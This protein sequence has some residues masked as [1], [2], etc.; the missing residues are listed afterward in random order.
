MIGVA[1]E[2]SGKEFPGPGLLAQAEPG[3]GL[4]KE[5]GRFLPEL[6]VVLEQQHGR[7]RGGK[8]VNPGG[9]F[10]GFSASGR[11]RASR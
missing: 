1:P 6:Q 9:G 2:D 11:K 5:G 4:Q 3:L 8:V 7:Q 10:W